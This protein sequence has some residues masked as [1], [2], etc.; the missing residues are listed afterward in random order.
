M[1]DAEF[2]SALFCFG[3]LWLPFAIV[4]TGFLLYPRKAIDNSLEMAKKLPLYDPEN[5]PDDPSRH[6]RA[7]DQ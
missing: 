1:T 4:G 6:D 3:A 5:V 2:V 7:N